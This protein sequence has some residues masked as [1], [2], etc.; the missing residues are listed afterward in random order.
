MFFKIIFLIIILFLFF[1]NKNIESFSGCL[2]RH[3]NEHIEIDTFDRN[4]SGFLRDSNDDEI[5]INPIDSP[6]NISI[7]R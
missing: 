5:I 6:D 2:P 1:R 7:S 4:I 3:Y